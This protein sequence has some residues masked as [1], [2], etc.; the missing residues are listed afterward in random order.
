MR[1]LDLCEIGQHAA[2]YTNNVAE[3]RSRPVRITW[4]NKET[5]ARTFNSKFT[6]GKIQSSVRD[7]RGKGQI[8]VIIPGYIDT[9]TRQPVMEVLI[10]KHP[11]MCIPDLV[12][13]E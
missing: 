1:R 4:D 3:S 6:N 13:P 9:K 7:I 2:L 12:D 8:G 5:E 11:T 10:D